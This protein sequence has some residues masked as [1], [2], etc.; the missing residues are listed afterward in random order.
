MKRWAL[1]IAAG[2]TYAGWAQNDGHD[3]VHA[4][5]RMHFVVSS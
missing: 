2:P 4:A 5:H 3:E 1:T